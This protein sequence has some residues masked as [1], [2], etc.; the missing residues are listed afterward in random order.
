M[1]ALARLGSKSLPGMREAFEKGVQIIIKNQLPTG[2]WGYGEGGGY[3]LRY[4]EGQLD[5][6]VELAQQG[7]AGPHERRVRLGG[8]R[9]S[10]GELCCEVG[11]DADDST[12]GGGGPVGTGP[13]RATSWPLARV[14]LRHS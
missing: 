3:R 8:G 4:V 13:P 12:R 2:G 10:V 1:Y 14:V 9:V 6:A 5:P 11:P 7:V